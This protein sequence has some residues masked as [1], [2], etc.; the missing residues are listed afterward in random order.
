[1]PGYKQSIANAFLPKFDCV[2]GLALC[3]IG[4]TWCWAGGDEDLG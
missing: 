1:M 4:S 2:F 3:G